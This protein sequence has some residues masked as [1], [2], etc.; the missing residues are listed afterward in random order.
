MLPS[1][2]SLILLNNSMSIL[3]IFLFVFIIQIG[4]I[5][6]TTSTFGRISKL[7]K[8]LRLKELTK[9]ECIFK[10]VN[11][12]F[13]FI[14]EHVKMIVRDNLN[15]YSRIYSIEEKYFIE[16]DEIHRLERNVNLS[17]Q[18]LQDHMLRVKSI[19]CDIVVWMIH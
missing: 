7:I 6:T 17:K 3:L 16:Y 14:V 18:Q 19:K 10:F 12:C 8:K 2:R 4:S 13:H 9:Q 1:K 5:I 11:K 15:S